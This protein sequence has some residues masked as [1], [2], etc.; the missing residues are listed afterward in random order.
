MTKTIILSEENVDNIIY[1]A[2]EIIKQDKRMKDIHKW[3]NLNTEEQMKFYDNNFTDSISFSFW[4]T[5]VELWYKLLFNKKELNYLGLYYISWHN[6]EL[7][8]V[9]YLLFRI[10]AYFKSNIK[11]DIL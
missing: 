1:Q 7:K 3:N 6:V 4:S 2:K 10:K 11:L 9:I 5:T 8:K